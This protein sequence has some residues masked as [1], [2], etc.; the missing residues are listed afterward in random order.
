MEKDPTSAQCE[1]A[2]ALSAEHPLPPSSGTLEM[3]EDTHVRNA[4]YTSFHDFIA[5]MREEILP[6]DMHSNEYIAK[7]QNL[8]SRMRFNPLEWRRYATVQHTKYTRNLVGHSENFTALLLVWNRNQISPIHDHD[9]SSGWVKVLFGT[10][11]ETQ[12]RHKNGNEGPLVQSTL[13]N[14]NVDDVCYINDSIGYHSVQ[15]THGDD[16]AVSLHLYSP[17]LTKCCL[18]E[19][20][21]TKKF[22]SLLAA[23]APYESYFDVSTTARSIDNFS[24]A[25]KAN[26]PPAKQDK[27]AVGAWAK[28]VGEALANAALSQKDWDIYMH[29]A[30]LH[31][32]RNLMWSNED[33]SVFLNCWRGAHCT[34][35]HSHGEGTHS[36]CRVLGGTLTYSGEGASKTLTKDSEIYYEATGLARHVMKNPSPKDLAVSIH[37]YSP[38]YKEVSYKKVENGGTFRATLPSIHY[39]KEPIPRVP[40]PASEIVFCTFDQFCTSLKEIFACPSE[41]AIRVSEVMA[42]LERSCFHMGE[43]DEIRAQTKKSKVRLFSSPD[44]S[45]SVE[46]Y[47][48]K[49]GEAAPVHDHLNSSMWVKVLKGRLSNLT[50]DQQGHTAQSA[51]LLPDSLAFMDKG[52]RHCVCNG[53]IEEA[54]T[55]H[56]HAPLLLGWACYDANGNEAQQLSI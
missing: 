55:L 4:A 32:T 25:L 40:R 30:E 54:A 6:I 2:T 35:E 10:L 53:T 11:Q 47:F 48:W 18:Y 33:Y 5:K 44:K 36:W 37:V 34:P 22:A 50:L 41:E 17:P 28:N 13:A 1:H 9:G 52:V 27:A 23:Y 56:V 26:Q 51:F 43:V 39:S 31:Y 49:L 3:G 38:P 24:S 42:Q 15:N 19:M 45:F 8:M 14:A 29:F 7:I 21:G 20:D 12:Y 16:V 46:L